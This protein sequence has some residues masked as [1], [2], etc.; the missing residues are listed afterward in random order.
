MHP[1]EIVTLIALLFGIAVFVFLAIQF[2]KM[3]NLAK[4][5]SS[6]LYIEWSQKHPGWLSFIRYIFPLLALAFSLQS[7]FLV[8]SIYYLFVK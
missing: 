6:Q 7:I 8:Y 2:F 5:S 1:V 4:D 3:A